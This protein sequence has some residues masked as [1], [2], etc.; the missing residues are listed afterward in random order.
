MTSEKK[1]VFIKAGDF[2]HTNQ[3]VLQIL[4]TNFP[5]F[6]IEVIDVLKGLISKKDPLAIYHC[7][8][9]FGIDILMRKKSLSD[10]FLRT[11]YVF[12]KIK[13]EIV[14]RIVNQ[15]Y[16]FTFQTQ[17]IFDA[18]VPGV[19]HFVYTDHTHL[20]NFNYVGFNRQKFLGRKWIELE[21]KIY[22]NATMNFT[23]S[24]NISRSIIND[25]SCSQDKVTCVFCGAN[26]QIT[27]DEI[28]TENRYSNINILFVGIDWQRKGGPALVEAFKKVLNVLPDATLTIV[29]CSPDLNLPNC[30]VVGR[31]PLA[32]LKKY[33][34]EA[35]VFCLPT[36]LEPFGIVFLE[37]MAH[38][39]P[40]IA[41]NIGAIS[42]FIHEGRNGYLVEPNNPVMLSEK[43]IQLLSTPEKCKTFGE[44]GQKL[45][46]EKYT[47]E[48][49]GP[50][51]SENI[52]K[53]IS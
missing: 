11:S 24:T 38:K 53:F 6:K 23:M 43:L 41:T 21:R 33:Y 37:A 22:H 46:W 20:E 14:K 31:I 12:K 39:L 47:W 15:E 35:S 19:P 27:K 7:F 36:T 26:V 3:S 1:L 29:G 48:K 25:Y 49:T 42:D 4:S 34:L 16:S 8:K 44:Y 51:I 40:I 13:R 32:E 45:F 2:S 10:S 9:E 5:D 52:I 50:K 28:F 17:S 30:K 18:S